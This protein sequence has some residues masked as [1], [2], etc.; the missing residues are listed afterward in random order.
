MSLWPTYLVAL[1]RF[2]PNILLTGAQYEVSVTDRPLEF[3]SPPRQRQRITDRLRAEV[4]EAYESGQTS[5]EVAE[6]FTIGRTTVLKILKAAGV[7]VRPQ[8]QK[9]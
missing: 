8:G 2:S 9:Y 5:R 1:G 4:V 3:A 7:T 6:M